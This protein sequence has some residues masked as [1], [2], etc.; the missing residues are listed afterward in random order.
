MWG[1]DV[2]LIVLESPYRLFIEP[3]L[4]YIEELERMRSKDETIT[5]VVPQF[6]PKHWWNNFLHERTADALRKELLNHQ[7]IIIMEVPYKIE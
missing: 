3:L 2:R 6:I 1:E 5:I 4:A 7:N